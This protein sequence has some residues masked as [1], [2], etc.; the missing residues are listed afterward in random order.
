[1]WAWYKG[2]WPYVGAAPT[3]VSIAT[4]Y[5]NAFGAWVYWQG[6]TLVAPTAAW[7]LANFSS[8]PLPAGATA[9][10]FGLAIS[11]MGSL[12]TDDYALA[13]NP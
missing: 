7:N 10:S 4:Y 5:R 11:G 2:Q 13:L 6:S 3:K 12:V 1:M 9:I 8:A